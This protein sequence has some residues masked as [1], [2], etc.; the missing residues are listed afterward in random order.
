MAKTPGAIDPKAYGDALEAVKRITDNQKKMNKD[1][2][3]SMELWGSI[4]NTVMGVSG[5]EFFEKVTKSTA[6]IA[7]QAKA[8]KDASDNLAVMGNQLDMSFKK[9]KELNAMRRAAAKINLNI[10]ES[11]MKENLLESVKQHMTED[12]IADT[13]TIA[14]ARDDL[15]EMAKKGQKIDKE[16]LKDLGIE[17]EKLSDVIKLTKQIS[18]QLNKKTKLTGEFE[19]LNVL[20]SDW[21]KQEYLTAIAEGKISKLVDKHGVGAALV[22]GTNKKINKV[23]GN[24]TIEYGE[25][26]K[27]VEELRQ[28][29]LEVEKSQFNL[30][31][32]LIKW[33]DNLQTL[34]L[35]RM[36]EFDNVIHRVQKDTGIMF[37]QNKRDM[38]NL[39]TSTAQFGMSVEDTAKF[40]GTM[41]DTLN[42]TRFDLLSKATED[43]KAVQL[44]TGMSSESLGT[45]AAEMMRMGESSA[46]VKQNIIG[47]NVTA[48][49]FGVNSKK[50]LE[51]ISKNFVKFRTMGFQGGIESLK[52]MTALSLRLGQNID[53]IFNMA[54]KARNIEGAMEMAAELQL[55]GG[56]FSNINPM[57]LLSAARKGPQELQK[58][59]GQMGKDIGKFDEK[60]GKMTF[61]PVDRDRLQIVAN[62]TGETLEGIQNRITK[63]NQDNKK[64][65]FMPSL[66]FDGFKDKN[67]D[68]ITPEAIKAQLSD[69]IDM[70]GKV[71]KG[72]LLDKEGI[73]DLTKLS[74]SELKRIMENKAAQDANLEKQAKE[75]QSLTDSFTALKDTFLNIFTILQPV[76]DVLTKV[77][78]GLSAVLQITAVKWVVLAVALTLF[79]I[80]AV[81]KLI[82]AIGM[83]GGQFGKLKTLFSGGEGGIMSK[84]KGKFMA[85]KAGASP[86]SGAEDVA[87]KSGSVKPK[88]GAGLREFAKNLQKVSKT[89]I[90]LGGIARFALAI[91]MMLV[92]I[93]GIALIFGKLG[94]D[95]LILAVMGAALVGMAFSIKLMSEVGKIDIK[96]ITMMALAMAIA[97]AALIPFAIGAKLLTGTDWGA[98][99][100]AVGIL[101]LI[102][103]GLALIGGALVSSGIGIVG[104]YAMAIGLVLVGGALLLFGLGMVQLGTGLQIMSNI[105]WAFVFKMVPALYLLSFGLMA[106]AFAG[107]MFVNPIIMIGMMLMVGTLAAIALTLVPLALALDMG[108]KGLDGM[109]AGVLKLNDSL[110][111][112]DF[113][114][115]DKLKDFSSA[116]ASSSASGNMA[117]AM[118]KL[119]EAMG[120]VGGATAGGGGAGTESRPIVI[121]LK[122]NGR[123]LTEEMIKSVDIVS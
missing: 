27:K 30:G 76:I 15:F 100:V 47:V 34:V 32:G 103:V 16:K 3:K 42:T 121:Q 44:A 106:F 52:T 23:L 111:K 90:D 80:S 7:E 89:K 117:E 64:L 118:G 81:P 35:K 112:L 14:K 24:S 33:A 77:L 78:Q 2:D 84:I 114:K 94:G 12:S 58:I 61:D 45:M 56:S 105:D 99:L 71:L 41:S 63:M 17:V 11:Q 22:L 88:A 50:A 104:L 8:Y 26:T 91:A 10:N 65:D 60:T 29:T 6:D 49:M 40:M 39:V 113:A 102:V 21:V 109:A 20:G 122:M 36:I 75:N 9:S 101:A 97:G 31:K 62:A 110:Q 72:S 123:V 28:K 73:K 98:A 92:P 48:K 83:M 59:L 25:S 53:E 79:A 37:T 43:L 119:A 115:L 19:N 93:A 5:S 51:S 85:G 116:M 38:T 120:K 87:N 1:L 54:D 108:S 69:S 82:G 68:D 86:L 57:D 4:S 46:E 55:A 70:A 18:N 96:N 13:K 95:P 107:L 74:Q 66:Q 67:G